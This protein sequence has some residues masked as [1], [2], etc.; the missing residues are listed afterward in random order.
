[1]HHAWRCF[2]DPCGSIVMIDAGASER[3]NADPLHLHD[4]ALCG[5]TEIFC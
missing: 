4:A 5:L 1:M 2:L 3:D